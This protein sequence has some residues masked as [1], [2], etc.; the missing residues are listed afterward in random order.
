LIRIARLVDARIR[1][2][3]VP[4]RSR[5]SAGTA[6]EQ[7][8]F[9]ACREPTPT[10]SAAGRRVTRAT[11]SARRLKCRQS[12][13][14]C[15]EP[16]SAAS[17]EPGVALSAMAD[18]VRFLRALVARIRRLL[19]DSVTDAETEWALKQLAEEIRGPREP[20]GA[21]G[22]KMLPNQREMRRSAGPFGLC[23]A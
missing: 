10:A 1:S 6:G 5:N 7:I 17:L 13:S 8:A 15:P 16:S 2:E 21:A 19:L 12:L 4:S 18:D 3:K 22:A 23:Y 11:P 14:Y 9:G 20:G